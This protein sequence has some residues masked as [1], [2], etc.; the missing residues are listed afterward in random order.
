MIE[1]RKVNGWRERRQF[2]TFPWKVYRHDPLWVPP[3][4]PEKMKVIDPRTGAFFKRGEAEFFSVWQ[5]GQMVGT[6]C[7]AEDIFTN[8]SRGRRDCVFGFLE[9]LENFAVFEAILDHLEQWAAERGLDTLLG[10]FHLDYEDSY[11]VLVSG[12]DRPPAL[13]CG[14]SPPY[15]L[16]FM[17][18]AG[19]V[20]ARAANLAF[21]IDLRES[22]Q[23]AR[24]AKIA[25]RLRQKGH[26]HI[27]QVDWNDWQG[28]I[29]R[30]HL[31]LKEALAWSDEGIP[32]HRDQLEAMVEPFR[33]IADPELILFAEVDG[34]TVGWFPGVPNLN[35]VF[36][37][38]NGLRYPWDYL[39]LL[40][41]MRKQPKSLTVK[42][43]LVL[44]EYQK[45]GAAVLLFDEMAKR[46]RAKGY[47][48]ADMSITSEDNPDTPQLATGMGAV[49]YKR[50]QVFQRAIKTS[51]G[52]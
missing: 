38:V 12:R 42:S 34:K 6:V 21:A 49:E 4:I 41:E 31:L 29:D 35:E 27:R 50:W 46:A 30:V 22:P 11:G 14:H 36:I 24:L 9:Y 19:F 51:E 45:R 47:Q 15:Y 13:M 16:D 44:P 5:D 33:Q 37:K 48:W 2:L 20:P 28:E 17:Q 39:R 52:S 23:Q 8:R 40:L 43:V 10:P 7:A 18:R 1:F 32:W 3:L 26:I 25:D